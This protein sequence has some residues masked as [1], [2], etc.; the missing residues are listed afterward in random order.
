MD[1]AINWGILGTGN[2]AKQFARG[3]G[4]LHDARIAAVGSRA[5]T[6]AGAFGDEFKI[7]KRYA[8]YEELVAD[9]E[10]DVV[11]VSTPHQLHRANTVLCLD[12]GKAVLCEKPFA[13]NAQE[14]AAMVDAARRNGVFL[15]EAM[16]TRFL[17][18]IVKVREWLHAGEIGEPRMV[19]ADFGFRAE[20]DPN[21]RLFNLEYGGG[22]LL[23]VGVYTISF[24]SMVFGEAP[25]R[26][27]GFAHIG[28]TG[29]DEHAAMVLGY[30]DGQVASLT[31][32]VRVNTPHDAVIM[33]TKG[34][35]RVHAPFWKTTGAVLKVDGKDDISFTMPHR[36]NGYEYQAEEVIRC[37]RAGKQE[38]SV[39]PLDESVSIIRTM[40]QIRSQWNLKYPME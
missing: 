5:K 17:P 39:M 12:A 32:A 37:L 35:I 19:T 1:R 9:P 40:D 8:S 21:G 22:G 11:Y 24:A 15:M 25:V 29:V 27:G 38:S 31:C 23:D 20:V 30:K 28:R 26:T 7:P 34:S 2:I 36:G 33:G 4:M 16:W 3:L 10:I 18:A 14:A 6:T 13:I